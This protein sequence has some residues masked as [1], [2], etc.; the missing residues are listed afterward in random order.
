MKIHNTYIKR[1]L[2]LAKNGLPEAMPNP[3]VGAVLVYGDTIIAEGYTT[4]YGGSHAEVNCIA[5]AK[6]NHPEKIEKSTLYVSLEPCSHYGKT[7][8]C[9]DLVIDSGIKK[10]VVGT[11]DPFAKVAGN[12]IKKLIQA[13]IDVTVGVLEAECYE[14]NK[15]FFTFHKL[16]R[17]YIILKWAET[18]DGFIAPETRDAQNPVWITNT[19]SRQLVHK[20]RAEEMGILV[21]GKTVL[22]D[23]PS[24]TT[25]DWEGNSPV[26]IVIDTKGTLSKDLAIF[27]S[28]AK[29]I[30]LSESDPEK[31]CELLF[32]EELQSV[33]IEGGAQTLQR[34]IDSNLWDEARVFVGQS[35]FKNGT[36]APKRSSDFVRLSS[37]SIK[38]DILNIYKNSSH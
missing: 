18:I 6:A 25:R 10:V 17:P 1:C 36:K 16:N 26:R 20:W 11:L 35:H 19:Y 21:G 31:I 14:L 13:G 33:I 37:E 28:S 38:G 30:V 15:R 9:A 2:E 4:A 32:K 5:F 27:D 22:A 3:S 12:G 7:P 34:F 24:L 8:P 29:T 23:N